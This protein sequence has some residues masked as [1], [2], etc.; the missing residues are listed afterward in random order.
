MTARPIRAPTYKSM[1][2]R[3]KPGEGFGKTNNSYRA[4]SDRKLYAL[5]LYRMRNMSL[6]LSG[7]TRVGDGSNSLMP[8]NSSRSLR[9]KS[10]MPKT[11]REWCRRPKRER[12]S[13]A[14]TKSEQISMPS[15]DSTRARKMWT[16]CVKPSCTKERIRLNEA[17]SVFMLVPNEYLCIINRIDQNNIEIWEGVRACKCTTVVVN[18]RRQ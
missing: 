7:K 16:A 6:S 5:Y 1:L 10:K 8:K 13:R 17:W 11:R 15:K 12:L 4:N 3:T 14:G 2:R 9:E 18:R